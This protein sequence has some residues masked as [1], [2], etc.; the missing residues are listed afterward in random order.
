MAKYICRSCAKEFE[1]YHRGKWQYCETHRVNRYQRWEQEQKA[2]LHCLDCGGPVSRHSERCRPCDS[3]HK[4]RLMEQN[5]EGLHNWK[6]GRVKDAHGYVHVLVPR[7][8]RKG[9]RYRAEHTVV[10]EKANRKSVPKDWVIHHKNG[11]KDD[12]RLENLEAMPR[13]KH[14]HQHDSYDRRIRELEAENQ[15]LREQLDGN[16]RTQ[17][18]T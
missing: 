15:R 4:A 17:I 2:K 5:H 16:L 10:W 9:R 3:E 1:E 6:G 18:Q 11:I 13:N 12:N 14:K 7:E 8:E